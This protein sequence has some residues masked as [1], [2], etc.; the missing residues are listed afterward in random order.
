MD[1][2]AFSL[3]HDHLLKASKALKYACLSVDT[4][5]VK[6]EYFRWHFSNSIYS[7]NFLVISLVV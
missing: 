3:L 6:K 4:T 2:T 5:K 1:K 7:Q